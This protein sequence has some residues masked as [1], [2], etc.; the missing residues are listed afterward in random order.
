MRLLVP[1]SVIRRHFSDW[2]VE[3]P[4]LRFGQYLFWKKAISCDHDHAQ[5]GT[6][7]IFH[8]KEIGKVWKELLAAADEAWQREASNRGDP[9]SGSVSEADREV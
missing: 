2:N 4:P 7:C 9:E 5:K 1:M 8:E 6:R 3:M